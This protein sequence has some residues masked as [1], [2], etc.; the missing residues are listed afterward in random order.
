MRT[1]L[2][3]LLG[4]ML[5]VLSLSAPFVSAADEQDQRD[6][7]E[8]APAAAAATEAGPETARRDDAEAPADAGA[9]ADSDSA[10]APAIRFHDSLA[11]AV[12]EDTSGKPLAVYFTAKWCGWCRKMSSFSFPDERVR[13]AARGFAWVKVDV[14]QAPELAARYAVQGVP[15]VVLLT[16]DGALIE[17]QAGYLAP[18]QLATFLSGAA[19]LAEAGG[20]AAEVRATVEATMKHLAGADSA[21]QAR[22]ALEPFVALLARP[23]RLARPALMAIASDLPGNAHLAEGLLLLMADDRLAIRA[24]AAAVLARQTG[25]ST[26]FDPFADPADRA[27]Q[28]EAWRAL[29]GQADQE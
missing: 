19:Q 9:E 29:L 16:R 4:L 8:G 7:T 22:E 12:S 27:R 26:P 28:I 2:P 10:P 5:A 18:K 14:D 6:A 1:Y 23:D 17:Q 13:E 3:C 11:L 15:Q 25:K 20:L 24:A 21:E